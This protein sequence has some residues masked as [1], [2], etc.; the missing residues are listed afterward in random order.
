M[1]RRGT[2][3]FLRRARK[4]KLCLQPPTNRGERQ[5]PGYGC[6]RVIEIRD[7]HRKSH[8]KHEGG[9]EEEEPEDGD[10]VEESRERSE[11]EGARDV[12]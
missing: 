9:R 4:P 10:Y 11:G 6:R 2:T 7:C 5:Y 8:G 3:F 1:T 12:V